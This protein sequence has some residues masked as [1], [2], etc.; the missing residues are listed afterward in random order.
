MSQAFV[1][2]RFSEAA[3]WSIVS[4]DMGWPDLVQAARERRID[5]ASRING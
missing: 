5:A 3:L 1:R 4:C 2:E